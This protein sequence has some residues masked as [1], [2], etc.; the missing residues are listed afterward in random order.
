[1][2]VAKEAA[3]QHKNPLEVRLVRG[4]G[5]SMALHNVD[6]GSPHAALIKSTRSPRIT[7]S[8]TRSDRAATPTLD[9]QQPPQHPQR[10]WMSF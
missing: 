7:V 8:R 9:Q 6:N 1:M 3:T 5:T 10:H 4:G 2:K